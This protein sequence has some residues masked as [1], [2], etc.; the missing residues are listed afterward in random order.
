MPTTNR[1]SQTTKILRFLERGRKLTVSEAR[2][3][4]GARKLSAR[5]CE[6]RND[7]Y[8]I[9]TVTKTVQGTPVTAYQL[10]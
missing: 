10:L 8:P 9:A 7:G 5:I 6:L 1:G 2:N 3:L 4:F